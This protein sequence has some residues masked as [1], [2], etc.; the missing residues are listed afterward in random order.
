MYD[1]ELRGVNLLLLAAGGGHYSIPEF[2]EAEEDVPQRAMMCEELDLSGAVE[3]DVFVCLT[4]A[5]C[6]AGIIV[7]LRTSQFLQVLF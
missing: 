7:W 6:R 3:E 1:D 5:P 4:S 2:L